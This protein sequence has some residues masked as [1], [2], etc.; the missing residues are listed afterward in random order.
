LEDLHSGLS[1]ICRTFSW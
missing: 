1:L